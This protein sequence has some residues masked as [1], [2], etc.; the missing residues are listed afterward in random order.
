MGGFDRS[1]N[2]LLLSSSSFFFYFF[3]SSTSFFIFFFFFLAVTIY[4][5]ITIQYN[6]I[7][8]IKLKY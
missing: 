6:K 3:L 7:T 2:H 4:N 5:T 1:I 8:I